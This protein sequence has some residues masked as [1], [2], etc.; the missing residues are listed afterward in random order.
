MGGS[1]SAVEL[2]WVNAMRSGAHSRPVRTVLGWHVL[3][4]VALATL[5][6]LLAGRHGALSAILGG[7]VS[8]TAGAVFGWSAARSQRRV[9]RF[10]EAGA[11]FALMGV[12]TAWVVKLVLIGALLLA[13]IAAYRGIVLWSFIGTFAVTTLLFTVVTFVAF[14]RHDG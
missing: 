7:L 12:L 4:T 11:G 1:C 14:T 13:A 5:S 6:G 2:T 10:P 8:L 9:A 3:A